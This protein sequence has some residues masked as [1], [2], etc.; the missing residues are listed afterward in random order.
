MN[1][2]FFLLAFICLIGLIVGL[3]RPDLVI[4]WEK[5]EKRTRKNVLKYY[6]LGL[7]LFMML[8]TISIDSSSKKEDRINQTDTGVEQ[9]LT[10]DEKAAVDLDEKIKALGDVQ[11][12]NLTKLDKVQEIRD[13]YDNLTL[14]Q[15]LL[16][17]KLSVLTEMEK[18]LAELQSAERLE[19]AETQATL[20]AQATIKAQQEEN[21][22]ESQTNEYTVY[23]TKTGSKYHKDG[24][25]YLKQSQISIS[26][27]A[28]I[29]QGYSPCSICNP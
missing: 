5:K 19:E 1:G 14:E 9:M 15:K 18:K 26:E 22:K 11:S 8:F 28:A 12:V 10:A 2:L 17:S 23:I 7:I 3:V 25:R 29:N 13:I 20:E 21:T 16:V 4:R 6:G 27:S 24:C